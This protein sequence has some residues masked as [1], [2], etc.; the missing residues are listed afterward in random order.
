[1]IIHTY[2]DKNKYILIKSNMETE[3]NLQKFLSS[4]LSKTECKK[5]K[6]NQSMNAFLN[7]NNSVGLKP[8]RRYFKNPFIS[9]KKFKNEIIV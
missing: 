3:R 6:T 5:C 2:L 4:L 9:N 7:T 1:M 8:S